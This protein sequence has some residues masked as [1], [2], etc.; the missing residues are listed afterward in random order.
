MFKGALIENNRYYHLRREQVL[1]MIIPGIFAGLLINFRIFPIWITVIL[2][3][4]YIYLNIKTFKNQ[5]EMSS[6][7]A[8]RTIEIDDIEI[9]IIPKDGTTKEI[10]NLGKIEKIS[11][12]YPSVEA[13][14]KELKEEIKGKSKKNFLVITQNNIK[15]Q[16]EFEIS[17]SYMLVQ[18]TK[19]IE[20]WK[21]KNYPLEIIPAIQ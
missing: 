10:I 3:G 16:L 18:L 12:K 17:S 4:I 19:A 1:L 13:S 11:I 20:K 9:R 6:M 14:M 8:K 2:F 21:T 7:T 15:R 5:K